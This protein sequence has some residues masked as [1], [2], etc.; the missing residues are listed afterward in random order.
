MLATVSRLALACFLMSLGKTKFLLDKAPL[1]GIVICCSC[2][3][4]GSKALK[5]LFAT[6]I[7]THLHEL[8]ALLGQ[9]N[10]ASRLIPGYKRIVRPIEALL[11]STMQLLWT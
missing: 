4:L 8:Q 7:P 1:L 3:C 10:F 9:L 6:A 2:Y 5:K 11:K